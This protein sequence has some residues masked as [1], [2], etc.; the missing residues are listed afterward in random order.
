[1]SVAMRA[2]GPSWLVTRIVRGG[3]DRRRMHAV[4]QPGQRHRQ[5][6]E[7]RGEEFVVQSAAIGFQPARCAREQLACLHGK[8]MHL[9]K[10]LP[11]KPNQVEAETAFGLHV[12]K[13]LES[14]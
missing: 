12:G 6:I 5:Q 13:L 4:E 14:L 1:M 8:R 7:F 9:V 2:G 3:G 10:S 11:C